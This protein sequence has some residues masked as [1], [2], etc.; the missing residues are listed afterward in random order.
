MFGTDLFKKGR[1]LPT[2]LVKLISKD[3]KLKH[4]LQPR[5]FGTFAER[6]L[7]KS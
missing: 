3:N 4:N 7:L 6:S 1:K 2:L 5:I